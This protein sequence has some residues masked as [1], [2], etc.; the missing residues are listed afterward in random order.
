MSE[1]KL[2]EQNTPSSF[3]DSD[4]QVP[5][6]Q[7][8]KRLIALP[9]VI[10][11]VSAVVVAVFCLWYSHSNLVSSCEDLVTAQAEQID[12]LKQLLADNED[13]LKISTDDVRSD[14]KSTVNS[15]QVRYKQ[16]EEEIDRIVIPDNAPAKSELRS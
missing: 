13:K 2:N 16:A 4:Q 7:S 12:E 6:G 9:L 14:D 8:K 5:K 10:T 11:L 3:Y 1:M 15:F